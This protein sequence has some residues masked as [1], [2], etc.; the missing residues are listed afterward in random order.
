MQAPP[1]SKAPP[2][3]R[4]HPHAAPPVTQPPPVTSGISPEPHCRRRVTQAPPVTPAGAGQNEKAVQGKAA[5]TPPLP[6]R[7]YTHRG[8]HASRADEGRREG[9]REGEGRRAVNGGGGHARRKCAHRLGRGSGQRPAPSS[10]AAE[11]DRQR[12]RPAHATS[13]VQVR[14]RAE[15]QDLVTPG[16]PTVRPA[17]HHERHGRGERQIGP[18]RAPASDAAGRSR[19]RRRARRR[20][21][22]RISPSATARTPRRGRASRSPRRHEDLHRGRLPCPSPSTRPRPVRRR[23][24]GRQG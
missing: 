19:C 7:C 4:H 21:R 10:P 20:R 11:A 24:R 23:P 1:V 16:E 15:P 8:H 14:R 18:R 3:R 13:G 2:D 12:I 9:R 6:R 5:Q 17:H 22:A